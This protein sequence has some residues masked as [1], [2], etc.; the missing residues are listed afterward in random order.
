[1]SKTFRSLVCVFVAVSMLFSFSASALDTADNTSDETAVFELIVDF[2]ESLFAKIYEFLKPGFTCIDVEAYTTEL[3]EIPGL[4]ED[5]VPQ[6]LCFIEEL[7]CFAVS[8]YSSASG[9]GDEILSRI[10]L[11]EKDTKTVKKLLLLSPD[12]SAFNY[13]AG[14]IAS[15][16][17]DLWVASG[18]SEKK[19]GFAYHIT[20]D[21]L[22]DAKSGDKVQ[23]DGRFQTE[24]KASYM[25][26]DGGMLWIGE[27]YNKD[28]PVNSA[29]AYGKNKAI[30]CGYK[31]P[32][33]VDYTS[34]E[35]LVPDV[36][37]SIPDQVQGMSITDNGEV[38]FS[39]SY[40]RRNNSVMHIF[41]DYKSWESDSAEIFNTQDIPLYIAENDSRITKITM[42]T[43]MEAYDYYNG[44]L[45][46][47]FESGAEKYSDARRVIKTVWET[48][49][50]AVINAVNS[51]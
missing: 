21:V 39:T 47:I 35:K 29:H 6:G 12:G 36:V 3:F 4:D 24:A 15:N 10:Y 7:D 13:H 20:T 41:S 23:F 2:F 5:F 8:G 11:I 19:G 46:M 22:S 26:C 1:M 48:D 42:P 38:V 25:Y 34:N 49:I 31:L 14:G 44:N 51:K 9:E 43:L 28:N 50:S 30:C 33:T 27:F 17:N 18:G 16:E 40:G 32:V 37:L 45:Y